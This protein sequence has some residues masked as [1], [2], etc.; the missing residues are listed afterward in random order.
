MKTSLSI[1]FVLIATTV[2]TAATQLID[3]TNLIGT[4]EG[5]SRCT[6]P[7]SPCTNEHVVYKIA[8]DKSGLGKARV[9]TYKIVDGKQEMMGTLDCTYRAGEIL[10]CTSPSSRKDRWEFRVARDRMIGSLIVGDDRTLYRRLGLRK[11]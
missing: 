5:D 3:V 6:I 10:D 11:K 7:T 1:A 4:W 8:A 9:D 2:L